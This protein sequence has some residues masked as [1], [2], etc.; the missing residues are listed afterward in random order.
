[1]WCHGL[2]SSSQSRDR[3]CRFPCRRNRLELC[4]AMLCCGFQQGRT[5]VEG[6]WHSQCNHRQWEQ[7]QQ[8]LGAASMCCMALLPSPDHCTARAPGRL[9]TLLLH[10]LSPKGQFFRLPCSRDRHGWCQSCL[11]SPAWLF[12]CTWSEAALTCLANRPHR[13]LLPP[14]LAN[15]PRCPAPGPMAQAWGTLGTPMASP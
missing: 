11:Y 12:P 3:P 7:R 4:H 1:M 5:E 2:S 9:L 6:G 10:L 14:A 13:S 8:G 15:F